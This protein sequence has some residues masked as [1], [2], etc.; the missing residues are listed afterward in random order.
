[1]IVVCDVARKAKTLMLTEEATAMLKR[2]YRTGKTHSYRQRCRMILLKADGQRSKDIA[3]QVSSCQ[4]SV[5]SW[6]RRYEAE[7][8]KKGCKQS[9]EE[10]ASRSWQQKIKPLPEPLLKRKDNVFAR[11]NGS[12]KQNWTSSST[13]PR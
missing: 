8:I 1:M 2:E 9:R 10:A 5:N 12:L 13:C 3:S 11:L 4:V 7:G 6:V